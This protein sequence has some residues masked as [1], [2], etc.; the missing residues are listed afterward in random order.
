MSTNKVR[1][2]GKLRQKRKKSSGSLFAA[3]DLGTNNCRLL[4]AKPQGNTF[5]VVDSHSQIARLGEGLHE[6]GH[7]SEAAMDRAIDA[8]AVIRGKLKA[9]GVGNIRCI[10]TEACRRAD[11]ASEFVRRIQD[12]TG[13]TFKIISAKEEARLAL[14]S[15]HNLISENAERVLVIDIGGGST[16]LSLVNANMAREGGLEGL[17]MR[18]PILN[19]TSLPLGVVT[20]SEA[21]EHLSEADAW[22]EMLTY[23][24]DAIQKWHG[25]DIAR[26]AMLTQ[27]AHIIGTSGTVTC[28]AGVHHKLETYRRD[29]VDGSWLRRTD[30]TLA[31]DRLRSLDIEGRAA[32]PT[33]GPGRAKLMLSGCAILQ[34]A[35]E[36]FPAE[37]L[38]VADRGL[39]EGLLLSMMYGPKRKRRRG[40]A[41]RRPIK[42][43]EQ[44]DGR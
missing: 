35:W 9:R 1:G 20:L 25:A 5:R 16:E 4:V 41:R 8:L 24:R 36:L 34:A 38:R 42:K 13:L 27:G 22:P 33:I 6:T 28:L 31:I 2:A 40:G 39:R 12:N 7:L 26:K 29:K 3:V 43:A 30:A 15:C 23:A 18:A 44:T 21:F 37:R 11:N 10:A 32:L 19:W 14:I 17:L